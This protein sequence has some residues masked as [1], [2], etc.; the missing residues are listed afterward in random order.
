MHDGEMLEIKVIDK[1]GDCPPCP[2]PDIRLEYET[3]MYQGTNWVK[4]VY[5][6]RCA[7]S[8]VCRYK[9]SPR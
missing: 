5:V 4:Q 6:M 1:V 2:C 9:E 8:R 3:G 7:H